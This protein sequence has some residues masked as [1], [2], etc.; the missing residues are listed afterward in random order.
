MLEIENCLSTKIEN[1]SLKKNL[2]GVVVF[3]LIRESAVQPI[4]IL[5]I[6]V[7]VSVQMRGGYMEFHMTH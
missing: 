5:R 4:L 1:K 7:D 3:L 2:H 6:R